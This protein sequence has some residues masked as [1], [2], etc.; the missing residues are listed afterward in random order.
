MKTFSSES[1]FAGPRVSKICLDQGSQTRGAHVAREDVLC[2]PRCF[3][4]IFKE[5][6]F[7]L[8]SLFIGV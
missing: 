2:S 1:Y 4:G 5:L 6:A 7:T 8:F 3:L